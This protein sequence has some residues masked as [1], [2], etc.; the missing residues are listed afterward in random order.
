MDSVRAFWSDTRANARIQELGRLLGLTDPYARLG[1]AWRF[2]LGVSKYHDDGVLEEHR[3]ELNPTHLAALAGWPGDPEAFFNALSGA[4]IICSPLTDPEEHARCTVRPPAPFEGGPRQPHFPASIAVHEWDRRMG[5]AYRRAREE[6]RRKRKQRGADLPRLPFARVRPGGGTEVGAGRVGGTPV[7]LRLAPPPVSRPPAGPSSLGG[8]GQNP[9]GGAGQPIPEPEPPH[10]NGRKNGHGGGTA[11]GVP[12]V[13]GGT[14]G[15]SRLEAPPVS[16]PPA[17]AG[18]ASR[19]RG[20]ES[21]PAPPLPPA[22]PATAAGNGRHGDGRTRGEGS[23][24]GGAPNGTPLA[25]REI[26]DQPGALE[27]WSRKKWN[28]EL[29]RA[30]VNAKSKGLTAEEAKR[31]FVEKHGPEPEE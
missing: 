19:G 24:E 31:L 13:R 29:W 12:I 22:T 8:A 5:R 17:A 30:L 26:L 25:L 9:R 20:R 21:S 3:G 10:R 4:W 14:G 18:I 28:R 7:H 27:P 2:Y 15:P 1:L 16:R 23:L 6:L 11:P